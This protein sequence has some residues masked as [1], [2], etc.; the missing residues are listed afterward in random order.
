MRFDIEPLLGVALALLLTLAAGPAAAKGGG[1]GC[2]KAASSAQKA[3]KLDVMAE[4]KLGEGV[5]YEGTEGAELKACQGETRDEAR[6]AKGECGDVREARLDVCDLLEEDIYAPELDPA[7]FVA[8]ID[9]AYAP[10]PVGAHWVYEGMTDAG[11]EHIEV[12]VLAETRTI[13]GI[14]ATVIQDRVF[15]D[16]E[17]V[18]DTIDWIA[19]DAE[20]NVWYLGEVA[21]NFEN[22]KLADLEG[23]WEHGEGDAVAGFWMIANPT[24]GDAYRQE[25]LL[26]EAEDIEEVIGTGEAVDVPAGSFTDC[27]RTRDY[28]PLEAD[29][30]E[31]KLHC[32]GVGFVKEV[33]LDTG[34]TLELIEYSMP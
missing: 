21:Q 34:E 8:V 9:N 4:A 29:V 33:K 10:F 32:P 28:T 22:G 20:G 5:C 31:N 11:L 23:S 16:G 1:S 14:V 18:E 13:E 25:M 27:V 12:D 3:C 15:V 7:S 17:I 24:L 26:G 30:I 19:Q 2:K 6:E